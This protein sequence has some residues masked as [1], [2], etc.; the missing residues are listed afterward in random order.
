MHILEE[1]KVFFK[2]YTYYN[3]L[4]DEKKDCFN[5]DKGLKKQSSFF[6]DGR[7]RLTTIGQPLE[8]NFERRDMKNLIEDFIR[9]TSELH[10]KEAK[11]YLIE[12]ETKSTMAILRSPKKTMIKKIKSIN[13]KIN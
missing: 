11:S 5:Y 1:L 2:K 9:K 8:L 6:K 12:I 4:E 3:S 10:M 7:M 13:K